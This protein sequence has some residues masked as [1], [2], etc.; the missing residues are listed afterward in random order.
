[1]IA[2]TEQLAWFIWLLVC[3]VNIVLAGAFAGME[4]GVYMVNKVRVELRAE[5]G[6]RPARALRKLMRNGDDILAMLLIGENIHQYLA[7]FAVSAMFVLGGRGEHAEWYVLGVTTPLLFVFKDSVPKNVFRRMPETLTYR[8]ARPMLL[9]DVLLKVTGLTYLVRVFSGGLLRLLGRKRVTHSLFGH[10]ALA[11]V[12]AEGHAAGTLTLS[13]RDMAHRVMNISRVRLTDVLCP[14]DRVVSAPPDESRE[15]FLR[16]I[17]QHDYSRLPLIAPDGR[18]VG[19]VDVY[20]VLNDDDARPIVEWMIDPLVIP[21]DVNVT[22]ALYTMQRAK[23]SL[24]IINEGGKHVGI[25]TIKDL[26]EEIVGEL[27]A[28]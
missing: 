22:Q 23:C 27:E 5:A 9:A 17:H 24:A 19:V 26:V 14:M 4:T 10:E 12:V 28:W 16:R 18:V 13:Q 20:D 6:S 2:I 1:M 8:L 3:A 15:D 21:A 7:A 11:S 25:I